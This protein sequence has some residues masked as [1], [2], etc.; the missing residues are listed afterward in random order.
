MPIAY[1]FDAAERL[2]HTV[3]TGDVH[4]RAIE[5]HLDAIGAEPWFPAPAIVDTRN[6]HDRAVPRHRLGANV[7]HQ[8]A[9][10]RIATP[11]SGRATD[12]ST[13]D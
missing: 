4:L 5:K 1:S 10:Q 9:P 11:A 3:V 13:Q 6:D 12:V 8:I 2:I 7:A